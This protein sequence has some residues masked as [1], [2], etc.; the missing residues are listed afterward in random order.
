MSVATRT[1]TSIADLKSLAI[2]LVCVLYDRTNFTW[3]SGNFTGQADDINVV[4]AD[5]TPL[6]TGAWVRQG[7]SA[8]TAKLPTA[9][10]TTRVLQQKIQETVSAQDFG[11]TGNGVTDDRSAIQAALDYVGAS[12]GG[13]V[14]L[15][16][17]NNQYLIKGGLKLPSF[18]TLSGPAAARYPYNAKSVL[19][20]D[21]DDANQWIIEPATLVSGAPVAYNSM[22]NGAFPSRATYNCAV[23]NLTV[24]SKGP[25]PYGGIRMHGAPGCMVRDVAISEVGCGLLVN[26]SFGGNFSVHVISSYYGVVAWD[27]ANAN[28]FEVYV[29]RDASTGSVPSGYLMPFMSTLNGNLVSTYR[30]SANE[31][32]NRSIGFVVGS[33]A[34][35]SINNVV[36]LVV[37]RYDDGA[38]LLYAYATDFRKCYMESSADQMKVA[39]TA[40]HSRFGMQTLHT[41]LSGGG[42]LFD[43]GIAVNASINPN[44][45]IYTGGY[46][47]GPYLDN[48]SRVIFRNSS[49]DTMGPAVPQFNISYPDLSGNWKAPALVNSWVNLGDPRN[50]AGYRINR[51]R[52]EF[53]G[54]INGGAS[55]SVAF[56]LP[57]GFRPYKRVLIGPVLIEPS[58]NIII[59]STGAVSLE[60]VSFEAVQ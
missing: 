49:P 59:Y 35:T 10:A 45:I 55:G 14:V 44:G 34:S 4:K 9:S 41:Y 24:T 21:F 13:T 17:A 20:A 18:T 58:G 51:N 1:A 26:F 37:E 47:V 38:F 53:Q 50:D 19:I 15:P 3:T 8:V 12:G 30:L 27:D 40:A 36:D 2:S 48:S 46:G 23:T 6:S 25:K 7:A 39:V 57:A 5:S 29:A 28:T 54:A 33:L 16:I 60:G 43:M 31:H 11:A 42:R 32:Y 22:I 56:I 52:V